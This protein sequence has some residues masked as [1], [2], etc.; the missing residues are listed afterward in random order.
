MG[1]G[2]AHRLRLVLA[3]GLVAG[4]LDILYAC[5]FWAL[6]AQ[7]PPTRILQSI[8]AG[9]LGKASFEGG[10]GTAALGLAL[11]FFIA[12]MM[13]AAYYMLAR[14]WPL[15][16]QRP[17]VCGAIYGLVLYGLMT[18]VVV[19]LSAAGPGPKDPLWIALSILAHTLLV[20]IPIALFVRR[21]LPAIR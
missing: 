5:A 4:T 3:G 1:D 16:R 10:I 6:K 7:V 19:P 13:S 2:P 14:T 21:A 18:Y 15:L 11:H 8:A 9:L 20:G 17:W 12:L